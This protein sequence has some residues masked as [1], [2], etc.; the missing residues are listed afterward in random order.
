MSRFQEVENGTPQGGILS[1]FLFHFLMEHLVALPFPE[2]T[3]LLSYAV[4]L[5]PVVTGRGNKHRHTHQALDAISGK[6]KEP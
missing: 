2:D 1:P 6:C 5:A 4:D 3:S